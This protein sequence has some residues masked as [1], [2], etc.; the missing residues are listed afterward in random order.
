MILKAI[1]DH[2]DMNKKKLEEYGHNFASLRKD[3][4]A[5][6]KLHKDYLQC[7]SR[8]LERSKNMFLL[9]RSTICENL[10]V[11]PEGE[12]TY[13]LY[14][15]SAVCESDTIIQDQE[16]MDRMKSKPLKSTTMNKKKQFRMA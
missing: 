5:L 2:L 12:G 9:P 6:E 1:N 13:F 10:I 4:E 3:L 8:V 15:T 16:W 7:E 14:L 11:G